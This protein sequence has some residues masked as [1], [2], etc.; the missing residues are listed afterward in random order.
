MQTVLVVEDSAVDRKLV[1]GLLEK[2]SEYNVIY[3]ENGKAALKQL[4]LHVPDIIVT[5]LQM[6]EM[7]GL[8][9]VRAVKSEYPLIPVV[10]I[11]AQGSEE[12]AVSALRSGAA[13]YVSKKRLAQDLPETIKR[14]SATAHEDRSQARLM[15]RIAKNETTFILHN[16]F[17]LM[18]SL[19]RYLQQTVVCLQLADEMERFR[20]GI[21]LEE[22]LQNA[23]YHGNLELSSELR[24]RDR[25]EY[26]RLAGQR[27]LEEPYC[28]RR[29]HVNA[30][31]SR[32]EATFVIRDEGPG[33]DPAQLP[34]PTDVT[35]LERPSGRGVLLMRTFMDEVR[36]NETGNEVTMTKRAI[37]DETE[38]WVEEV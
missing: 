38:L 7:D 31:L 3:A 13:S 2:N 21:A 6:P 24:V 28:D 8:Q 20:V 18:H 25:V 11:T 1:G 10:L 5:D 23:L 34:D 36:Y 19:V 17:A 27:C 30:K 29:I 32:A 4:E 33:F 9:L 12:I 37:A 26:Q 15:H 35:N 22:A 14:V 16:D